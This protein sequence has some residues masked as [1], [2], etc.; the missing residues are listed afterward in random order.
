MSFGVGRHYGVHG[1]DL[2]NII[3]NWRDG[4]VGIGVGNIDQLDK[5]VEHAGV[6]DLE[7]VDQAFVHQVVQATDLQ[8]FVQEFCILVVDALL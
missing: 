4:L 6:L 5:L 8:G 2:A 3:S 1:Y 7:Q